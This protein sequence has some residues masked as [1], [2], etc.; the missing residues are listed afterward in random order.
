MAFLPVCASACVR[1]SV[2]FAV[3]L[4]V[5]RRLEIILLRLSACACAQQLLHVIIHLNACPGSSV[6][7]YDT[8]DKS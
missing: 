5:S 3:Y 2:A 7:L 8:S 1:G 6:N 4:G